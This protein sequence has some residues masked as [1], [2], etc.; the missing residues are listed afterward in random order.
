MAAL[1]SLENVSS[2]CF[3]NGIIKNCYDLS[4][5]LTS[6][7]LHTEYVKNPQYITKYNRNHPCLSK[8]ELMSQISWPISQT[9]RVGYS[10]NKK[11]LLCTNWLDRFFQHFSP[12]FAIPPRSLVHTTGSE[13]KL[14]NPRR[15]CIW[16][17]NLSYYASWIIGR[18]IDIGRL[19]TQNTAN[20]VNEPEKRMKNQITKRKMLPTLNSPK[21][22]KQPAYCQS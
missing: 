5:S 18:H 2:V 17:A 16:M 10:S 6:V 21:D 12:L 7:S 14:A 1:T 19:M 15:F 13:W 4:F 9:S 3:H 22:Q 8:M 20:Q 11:Y